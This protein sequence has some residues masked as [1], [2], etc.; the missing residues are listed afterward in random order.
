MLL[1]NFYCFHVSLKRC[2][3]RFRVCLTVCSDRSMKLFL[4]FHILQPFAFSEL[5]SQLSL[6]TVVID[7]CSPFSMNHLSVSNVMS[8]NQTAISSMIILLAKSFSLLFFART[9]REG[10]GVRGWGVI[11]FVYLFVYMLGGIKGSLWLFLCPWPFSFSPK[12]QLNTPR[13]SPIGEGLPAWPFFP[14][15][16]GSHTPTSGGRAVLIGN[17]LFIPCKLTIFD[18]FIFFFTLSLSLKL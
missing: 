14:R 15:N 7:L 8:W 16:E 6:Q 2:I 5:C 13:N 17:S 1:I 3:E 18:F 11:L 10:G 12:L 9:V 4:S